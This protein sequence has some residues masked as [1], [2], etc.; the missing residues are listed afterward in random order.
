MES[1]IADFVW[2][3]GIIATFLVLEGRLNTKFWDFFETS[4][5]AKILSLQSLSNLWGNRYIQRLAITYNI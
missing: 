4:S 1:L 2:L 5:F 3:S